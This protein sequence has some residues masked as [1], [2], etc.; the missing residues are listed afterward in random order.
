MSQDQISIVSYN[1]K[2][3][4]LAEAEKT[5]LRTLLPHLNFE[6]EHIGSTAIPDLPAK[7]V[8]DLVV[9][10]ESISHAEA[11]I[12]T[13]E[14]AGYS[15]WRDNPN[16]WHF[17]FVKGL[18]LAGGAGRTHHVHIVEKGHSFYRKQ[19]LFRDFLRANPDAAKDY[20]KL[21]FDLANKFADDR[22]AYTNGKSEFVNAILQKAL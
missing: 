14:K 3:P 13:L 6:I 15:Y 5:L 10:V 11:T 22:E 7:P 4:D 12:E 21:K 16:K 1:P 9:G 17:F 19:I 18:P 8:I 2:W 20:L